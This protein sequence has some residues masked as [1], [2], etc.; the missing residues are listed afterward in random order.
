[1]TSQTGNKPLQYAYCTTFREINSTRVFFFKDY[2]ENKAGRL[3]PDLLFFFK[4]A[5]YEL[6]ASGM[7]PS[8]NI[9]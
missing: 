1:M 7:Y 9:F 6:K 2:A 3:V 5:S 8:F 4:K